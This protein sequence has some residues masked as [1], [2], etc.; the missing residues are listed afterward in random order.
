MHVVQPL[1]SLAVGL[2]FGLL[3]VGVL[4]TRSS[5]RGV[6]RHTG[7]DYLLAGLSALAAFGIAAFLAYVLL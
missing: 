2:I 5:E 4:A 3:T 7:V 1:S 6:D